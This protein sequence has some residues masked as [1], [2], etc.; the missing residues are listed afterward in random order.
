MI[1]HGP[2]VNTSHTQPSGPVA[3]NIFISH[4]NTK[5]KSALIKK[6]GYCYL[7]FINQPCVVIT[8]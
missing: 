3:N 4:N 6:Y 5:S 1:V 2:M 8:L 7:S